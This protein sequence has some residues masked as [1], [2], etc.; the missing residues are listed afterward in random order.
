MP[1]KDKWNLDRKPSRAERVV[2]ILASGFLALLCA[3]IFAIT[4]SNQSELNF[5]GLV[6]LSFGVL[7]VIFIV[8]FCRVA[9]DKAER[10][11]SSTIKIANYIFAIAGI[12][13]ILLGLFS[14]FDLKLLGLGTIGLSVGFRNLSL[15]RKA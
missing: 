12:A 10:P 4:F 2:G 1:T 8:L 6:P 14:N 11:S 9:F 3:V 5:P 15:D 13:L 7:T